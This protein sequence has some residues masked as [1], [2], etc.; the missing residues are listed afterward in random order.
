MK[1]NKKKHTKILTYIRYHLSSTKTLALYWIYVDYPMV[2]YRLDV[3][4]WQWTDI[5][6]VTLVCRWLM[7]CWILHLANIIPTLER[8]SNRI[9][10]WWKNWS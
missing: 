7:K 1:T 8:W 5:G 10:I 2:L 6:G 3:S 4:K 9:K